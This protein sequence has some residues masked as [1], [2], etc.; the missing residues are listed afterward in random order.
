MSNAHLLEK[1]VS[2]LIYDLCGTLYLHGYQ[3]ISLGVLMRLVGVPNDRAVIHDSD[4]IDIKS[5]FVNSSS[6]SKNIHIPPGTVF[7]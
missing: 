3:E 5:H 6:H 2:D 1:A 7:H 4:I